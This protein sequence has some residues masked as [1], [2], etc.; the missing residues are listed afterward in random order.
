MMFRKID[1]FMKQ[2]GFLEGWH[3]PL[4]QVLIAFLVALSVI[5]SR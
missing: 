3:E 1:A 2:H 4:I 5:I